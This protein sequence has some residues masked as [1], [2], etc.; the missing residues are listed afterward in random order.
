[1]A[2]PNDTASSAD[3]ACG[4]APAKRASQRSAHATCPPAAGRSLAIAAS[5]LVC[6]VDDAQIGANGAR[7]GAAARSV[8]A[9]GARD[10]IRALSVIGAARE[11]IGCC[12]A[13]AVSTAT[14]RPPRP[15]GIAT[16][17][18]PIESGAAPCAAPRVTSSMTRSA[19]AAAGDDA[20]VRAIAAI[21]SDDSAPG[22]DSARAT[23]AGSE[24]ATASTTAE[25][26]CAG[27]SGGLR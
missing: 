12:I 20:T 26:T 9:M 11:T 17:G 22:C 1:M 18:P 2:A 7:P 15:A 10:A 27:S 21:V 23:P 3:S 8:A 16:R 19:A 4:E 24:G 5:A 25:R 13:L 14:A 6:V